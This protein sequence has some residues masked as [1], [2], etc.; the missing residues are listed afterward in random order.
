MTLVV[1]CKDLMTKCKQG[2]GI[3]ALWNAKSIIFFFFLNSD[4]EQFTGSS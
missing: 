4:E 1:D 2:C 3:C